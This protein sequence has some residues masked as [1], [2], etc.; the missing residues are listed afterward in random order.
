M[1][2]VLELLV[3]S[4]AAEVLYDWQC[5]EPEARLKL[6][7]LARERSERLTHHL[8]LGPVDRL[9]FQAADGR[10][11]L[12]FQ[13]DGAVVLRSGSGVKPTPPGG[14]Q[15]HQSMSGW[16]ARHSQIS[17]LLAASVLRPPQQPVVHSSLQEFGA[18]GLRLACDCIQEMFDLIPT[19]GIDPWQ[20]R[21]VYQQS[22][23]YVTRRQDGKSLAMF[24][25]KDPQKLESEAVEKVFNEFKGLEAA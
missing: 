14:G 18:D 10:L 20:M 7:G 19:H 17:G 16:L 11:L 23:L 1:P 21:W 6:V 13:E 15:F 9:E 2:R 4:Y 12:Y 22:Q 25:T 3:C 8:P 24:L 5:A